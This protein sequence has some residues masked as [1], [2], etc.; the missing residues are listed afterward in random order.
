MI[1]I[2][3]K[4]AIGIGVLFA[5]LLTVSIMAIVFINMLSSKTEKLLTANYNTIRYCSEMSDAIDNIDS[6]AVALV[7][8]E[9]NLKAQENN[10]TEPGEAEATQ[11]LR[12]YFEEIKS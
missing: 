5:L 4:I 3:S 9:T 7:K 6:S 10:I 2:K 11:K 8:F 1:S 12:Y